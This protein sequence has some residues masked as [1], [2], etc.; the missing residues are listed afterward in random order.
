MASEKYGRLFTASDLEFMFVAEGVVST[1]TEAEQ[2]VQMAIARLDEQAATPNAATFPPDEPLFL[3][4]A[5]G[6]ATAGALS[7]YYV[8]SQ[9]IGA[10][11]DH[12]L[13]IV[14]AARQFEKFAIEHPERRKVP[15]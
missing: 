2:R 15:D 6:R 1:F 4:R 13:A 7:G 3:L 8:M 14:D 12:T 9:A 5:Q 10:S 11:Q